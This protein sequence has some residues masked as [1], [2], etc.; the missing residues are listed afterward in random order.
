MTRTCPCCGRPAQGT[1]PYLWC[2]TTSGRLWLT[3]DGRLEKPAQS[4]VG[5][6]SR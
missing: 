6:V 4:G 1:G 5:A 2:P 3:E